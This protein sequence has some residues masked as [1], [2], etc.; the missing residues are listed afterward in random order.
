MLQKRALSF[1]LRD[2]FPE[3]LAGMLST[4]EAADIT[5]GDNIRNITPE[6]TTTT[7]TATAEAAMEDFN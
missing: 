5:S 1:A 2:A 4:D 6:A 7:T 3:I